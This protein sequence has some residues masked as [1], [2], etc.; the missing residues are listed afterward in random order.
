MKKTLIAIAVASFFYVS[1]SI[2]QTAPA[3]GKRA[4]MQQ[5]STHR[6]GDRGGHNF[7]EM[8][9]LTAKDLPASTTSFIKS[10]YPNAEMKRIAKSKD[11]K[12]F[13]VLTETDK[14]RHMLIADSKGNILK[15]REMPARKG[16]RGGKKQS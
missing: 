5:D 2:A 16:G 1:D 6:R 15:D 14:P 7:R 3:T 9:K 10:K 4:R 13:V 8:E 12:Y 11:D